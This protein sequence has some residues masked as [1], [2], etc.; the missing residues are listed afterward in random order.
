MYPVYCTETVVNGSLDTHPYTHA[1]TRTHKLLLTTV[2]YV[3]AP[4][5]DL[6]SDL[7]IRWRLK[8]VAAFIHHPQGLLQCLLKSPA[9]CHHFTDTLHR[10]TDLSDGKEDK[11]RNDA[12]QAHSCVDTDSEIHW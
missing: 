9:N 4:S 5:T 11:T 3:S 6:F 2:C 10:R 7:S 8:A 12:V 1:C